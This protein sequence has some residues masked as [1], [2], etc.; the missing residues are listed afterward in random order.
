MMD[1]IH[2]QFI[3]DLINIRSKLES[4][5]NIVAY[6]DY[7]NDIELSFSGDEL[8]N[9][10]TAIGVYIHVLEGGKHGNIQGASE[11]VQEKSKTGR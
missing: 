9:L 8:C 11:D 2:K 6:D 3:R 7:G 10:M 4:A 1:Y 5:Y